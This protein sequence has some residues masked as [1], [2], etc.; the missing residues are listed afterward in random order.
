MFTEHSER[1]TWSPLNCAELAYLAIT[2]GN[3][4]NVYASAVAFLVNALR[5]PTGLLTA[6]LPTGMLTLNII[7]RQDK[8]P[9]ERVS[10]SAPLFF[11]PFAGFFPFSYK[12]LTTY[13]SN[14]RARKRRAWL[15]MRKPSQRSSCVDLWWVEQDFD[16]RLCFCP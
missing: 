2:T 4:I 11:A 1:P 13:S 14:L 9:Y 8:S 5:L 12:R 10:A 16:T 3:S 15:Q 6:V 7:G